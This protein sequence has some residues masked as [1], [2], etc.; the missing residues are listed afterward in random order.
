MR[1]KEEIRVKYAEMK[2]DKNEALSQGYLATSECGF[3]L[4][5]EWLQKETRTEEEIRAKLLELE[6]KHS[7]GILDVFY[8]SS[9]CVVLEW[10][11]E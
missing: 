5:L 10:V 8:L 1:S 3:C 7:G 11:L 4:G 2:K 9:W 6:N